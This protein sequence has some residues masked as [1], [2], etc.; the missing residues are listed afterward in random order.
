MS[1]TVQTSPALDASNGKE[2]HDDQ[3]G[4]NKEEDVENH[5]SITERS[6]L[7]VGKRAETGGMT[8]VA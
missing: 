5:E 7:Q 3:T 8:A 4:G 2:K 6:I 1:A